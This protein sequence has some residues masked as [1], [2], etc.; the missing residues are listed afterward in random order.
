[1]AGRSLS[2]K[3]FRQLFPLNK[4]LVEAV[5][6]DYR[7]TQDTLLEKSKDGARAEVSLITD[8]GH[9]HSGYDLFFSSGEG[10]I[11][12]IRD[13]Y[14]AI[15]IG[16]NACMQVP[17]KLSCFRG[18]PVRIG[19]FEISES[20]VSH[21]WSKDVVCPAKGGA[22]RFIKIQVGSAE[23][24]VNTYEGYSQ[25]P[26]LIGHDYELVFTLPAH[27]PVLY[28]QTDHLHIGRTE[29]ATYVFQFNQP[30]KKFELPNADESI[31]RN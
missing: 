13:N 27:V 25:D 28:R 8:D 30:V 12:E 31:E 19:L 26:Q 21:V 14:V 5:L 11:K 6:G 20:H 18:N 10:S 24:D 22:C 1:M 7:Q 29:T 9:A 3:Q 16:R 15:Q 4:S 17:E 23:D 2:S